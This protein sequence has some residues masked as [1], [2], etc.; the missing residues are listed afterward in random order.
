MLYAIALKM[1]ENSEKSMNPRDVEKILIENHGQHCFYTVGE[2]NKFLRKHPY[3][4]H[5]RNHSN[6]FLI[7]AFTKEYSELY[8]LVHGEAKAQTLMHLPRIVS[9]H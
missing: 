7:P 6:A 4:I 8:I 1:G 3:S 9:R 2:I 5:V